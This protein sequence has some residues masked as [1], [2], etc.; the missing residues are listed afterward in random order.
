MSRLTVLSPMRTILPRF[1]HLNPPYVS[2]L[3]PTAKAL[4]IFDVYLAICDA[5]AGQ[6]PLGERL[7]LSGRREVTRYR[8]GIVSDRKHI[9]DCVALRIQDLKMLIHSKTTVSAGHISAHDFV[10]SSLATPSSFCSSGFGARPVDQTS[11]PCGS[12]ISSTLISLPTSSFPV[13]LYPVRS[14]RSDFG[15]GPRFNLLPLELLLC[16]LSEIPTRQTHTRPRPTCRN[17]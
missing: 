17:S 1:F 9:W 13:E 8:H 11:N 10:R 14:H 15:I 4:S 5:T 6:G 7:T 2:S 3:A 12:D 16:I